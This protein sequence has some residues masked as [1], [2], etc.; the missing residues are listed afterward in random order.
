MCLGREGRG[1]EG[2]GPHA[3]AGGGP[4]YT[5]LSPSLSLP[6][7]LSLSHPLPL[8]LPHPPAPQANLAGL[9]TM[10]DTIISEDSEY[11]KLNVLPGFAKIITE[12]RANFDKVASEFAD[13]ILEKHAEK[14][15]EKKLFL[16]VVAKASAEAEDKSIAMIQV[17]QHP[18]LSRSLSLSLSLSFSLSFSFSLSMYVCA[19]SCLYITM[20]VCACKSGVYGCIWMCVCVLQTF[21]A[22]KKKTFVE[23]RTSTR[24]GSKRCSCLW[25]SRQLALHVIGMA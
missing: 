12:Y 19:R 11:N 1:E 24:D 7:S 14:E 23:Y 4:D 2:A 16:S 20:C 5:S 10:L 15:A 17:G 8:P 13:G 9:T 18:P 3:T 21:E 6:P 22:L 25:W